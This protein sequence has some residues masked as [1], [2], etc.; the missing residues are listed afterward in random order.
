M[1]PG[2]LVVLKEGF[3]SLYLYDDTCVQHDGT[4]VFPEDIMI[5]LGEDIVRFKRW[6]RVFNSSTQKIGYVGLG[7]IKALGHEAR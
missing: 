1:K 6:A 7:L 3:I 5:Y 4:S 2:D